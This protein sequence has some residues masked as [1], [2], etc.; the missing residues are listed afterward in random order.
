M[1]ISLI[2][3]FKFYLKKTKQKKIYI[4][5]PDLNKILKNQKFHKAI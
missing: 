4:E 2:R 1:I 3:E 5:R